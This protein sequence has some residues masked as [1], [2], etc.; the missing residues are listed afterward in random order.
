GWCPRH[1]EGVAHYFFYALEARTGKKFLHGQ[2]V[3]LG[4]IVGAMMH[5]RRVQELRDVIDY[6]GVDIRPESMGIS[7]DD[8]EGSL[9]GLSDFVRRRALPYGIAHDVQ[10]TPGFLLDLRRIVGHV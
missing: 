6:I 3:C 1:I 8:V 7:W 5:E 4:I 9:T 10:V 2:A